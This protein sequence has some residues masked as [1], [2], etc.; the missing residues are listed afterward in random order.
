MTF[1]ICKLRMKVIRLTSHPKKQL[2]AL[3]LCITATFGNLAFAESA[4]L[5]LPDLE[6]M[7]FNQSPA[8]RGASNAVDAARAAVDT[9]RT[10]PNPQIEVMNGTRK[11]RP[12][13]TTGAVNGNVKSISI[14]QDLDMPWHRF[15]RVDGALAGYSAA[16]A[17][18]Q[19]FRAD[20]RAQLRLRY[21]DLVRR[22]A[23]NRVAAEDV[24]LM[25]GIHKRIALQVETGEKAR[26]ELVKANAELL[27]AQ[28]MQ[29]SAG[30]RVR[31][32]RGALRALVGVQLPESFEVQEQ[33]H[34][35]APPSPLNEVRDEVLKS[36]PE[37]QR[38]RAERQQL[39][40]K[41]S[42]EKAL[43]FP[44]F[45][46]RA[47]QDQ[48]PEWRSK[49]IGV[50]MNLPLWD[51][52]GGPVGEAAAKLSQS[53]NQMAYQEFS[54]LQSLEAAYQ[55]YDIA[56]AQVV[57][58]EGGIVRHAANALRIAELAYKAGEKSF[59]DVMDAQRVYRAARNE[60]ITAQFE[61]AGAWAEIERLRATTH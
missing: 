19:S 33:T 58:L 50:A 59:L 28:K 4:K 37:L 56:N 32:A 14:T 49:R 43:R 40:R 23:E 9:A 45:A 30:L 11:P 26:F 20:M 55:Q 52:R 12:D 7:M 1:N 54:L 13:N 22:T 60:L 41:L 27:N 24:K 3:L 51:W 42:E 61:L 53:D 35:F 39:D 2:T 5:S 48:D 29:E 44:K 21:Y 38:T 57:A 6:S 34:T 17:N 16:Q 15:P 46:L 31:Q 47:D 10:I 25:E 18:E 36:N 8:L